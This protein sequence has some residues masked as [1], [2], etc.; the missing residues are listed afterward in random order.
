MTTIE[1]VLRSH[2]IM[3]TRVNN[4]IITWDDLGIEEVAQFKIDA[5]LSDVYK[6]LGY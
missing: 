6:F 3:T 5:N 1:K 2:G 4:V